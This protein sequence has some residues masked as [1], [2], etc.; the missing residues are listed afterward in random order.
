M[1]HDVVACSQVVW[2]R[3]RHFTPPWAADGSLVPNVTLL[4]PGFGELFLICKD[5]VMWNGAGRATCA[6]AFRTPFRMV[7]RKRSCTARVL[8]ASRRRPAAE[9]SRR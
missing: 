8:A 2:L 4:P 6:C 9:P 7:S 3:S 1:K 5:I